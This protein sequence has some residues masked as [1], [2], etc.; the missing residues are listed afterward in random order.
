MA[1]LPISSE[2]AKPK[3]M[4]KV[5]A[6][7]RGQRHRADIADSAG[8]AET[9]TN[10]STATPI[11]ASRWIWSAARRSEH[12]GPSR[13]PTTMG[14]QQRL[15]Q[16]QRRWRR[17]ADD[18]SRANSAKGMGEQRFHVGSVRGRAAGPPYPATAHRCMPPSR[19]GKPRPCRRRWRRAG[20]AAATFTAPNR[21]RELPPPPR[22]PGSAAADP[23]NPRL[24]QADVQ[25]EAIPAVL[26]A[27]T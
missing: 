27:A 7:A 2:R 21:R 4:V 26:K 5:S 11:S 19:W 9:A 12:R 18:S 14:D 13:M 24:S 6:P 1:L 22:R 15:T 25:A 3:M 8:R 23:G 17:P 10:S 16:A 20:R